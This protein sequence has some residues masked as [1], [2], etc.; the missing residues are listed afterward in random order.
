MFRRLLLT[1]AALLLVMGVNSEARADAF[2]IAQGQ[3]VNLTLTSTQYPGVTGTATVTLSGNQLV[4]TLTNTSTNPS[5]PSIRALGFDTTPNLTASNVSFGGDMAGDWTTGNFGGP[6]G[7]FEFAEKSTQGNRNRTLEVGQTGT[8]TL[9][10]TSAPTSITF[11]RFLV[12]FIRLPNDDS[13]WIG[14]HKP[15]TDPIP[16][17]MTMLLL[18][19]GLAGTAA[20]VRRRR[21]KA[22]QQE[23]ERE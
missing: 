4:I 7:N 12:H 8:I 15:P 2:T 5:A 6:G 11:D 22:Q 3:T 17:P 10:L 13:E 21:R 20:T 9:T 19:T 14:P 23:A 1:S 18:G 16:E